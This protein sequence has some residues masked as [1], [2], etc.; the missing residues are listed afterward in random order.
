MFKY[1]HLNIF[2]RAENTTL[3]KRLFQVCVQSLFVL[4]NSKKKVINE[5][6]FSVSR[7]PTECT[8]TFRLQKKYETLF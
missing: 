8:R 3:E 5:I 6:V 4:S 7:L 1:F 2:T